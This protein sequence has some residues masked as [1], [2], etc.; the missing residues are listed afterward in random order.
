MIN[1]EGLSKEN[2]GRRIKTARENRNIEQKVLAQMIGVSFS[3]IN[4]IENGKQD[5]RLD[6]LGKISNALN[7]KIEYLLGVDKDTN[8]IDDFIRQF[9]RLVLSKDFS[10]EDCGVYCPKKLLYS[11]NQDYIVLTGNPAI[12]QL[13]K[14]IATISGQKATLFPFEYKGR[15]TKAWNTYQKEKKMHKETETFFLVSSEQISEIVTMIMKSEKAIASVG[16][17]L[18]N[19][20]DMKSNPP[21]CL[22]I[23]KK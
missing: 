21:L 23:N 22:K 9:D 19:V 17:A 4:K 12:F 15:I 2:V 20:N 1:I 11:I 6:L 7:V 5:I 3:T 8:F 10:S 14:Q 16:I 13:I 18:S